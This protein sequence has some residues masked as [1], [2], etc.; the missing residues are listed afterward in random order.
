MAGLR[1]APIRHQYACLHCCNLQQCTGKKGGKILAIWP[2]PARSDTSRYKIGG[3]ERCTALA[4]M[5]MRDRSRDCRLHRRLHARARWHLDSVHQE[6]GAAY[7]SLFG[8]LR[9]LHNI[10]TPSGGSRRSRQRAGCI[11]THSRVSAHRQS[12][13]A[14]MRPRSVHL[15]DLMHESLSREKERARGPNRNCIPIRG[16]SL[17]TCRTPCPLCYR[18]RFRR[19]RYVKPPRKQLKLRSRN[20]SSE[21]SWHPLPAYHHHWS[22]RPAMQRRCACKCTSINGSCAASWEPRAGAHGA[23]RKDPTL[24]PIVT[25]TGGLQTGGSYLRDTWTSHDRKFEAMRWAVSPTEANILA[26]DWSINVK[27]CALAASSL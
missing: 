13:C 16:R 17:I 27:T 8:L 15:H 14:D 7:A 18:H 3:A 4:W 10:N 22:R 5:R 23:R 21:T 1:L 6:H 19:P 12:L 26:I 11:C 9:G 20:D 25:L 2:R 24:D